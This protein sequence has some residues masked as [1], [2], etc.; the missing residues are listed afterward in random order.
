MDKNTTILEAQWME[1]EIPRIQ[2]ELE[3][4]RKLEQDLLTTPLDTVSTAY[5]E[6]YRAQQRRAHPYYHRQRRV[7][8]T[9]N[10][11]RERIAEVGWIAIG[12]RVLMAIIALLAIYVAYH[13]HQLGHTQRGIIWS[14]VLLVLGIALA[15]APMIASIYWERRARHNAELAAQAAQRS[16]VF[17]AEKQERQAQ[18]VQ[19]RA[20]ISK[21]DERLKTARLRLDELR[22]EL[23]RGNNDR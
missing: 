3:A 19:C 17:M 8:P 20:R 2:H 4:L 16:E 5:T 18:L 13:N 12:Y 22:E 7:V 21:L 10:G 9:K 6:T 1:K 11:Y 15:F 23:V 14:S